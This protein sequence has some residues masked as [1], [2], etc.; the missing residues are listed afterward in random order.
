M[1]EATTTILFDRAVRLIQLGQTAEGLVLLR[2]Y[3]RLQPRD[4]NALLWLAAT[5]S[6]T[7]EKIS[8]AGRILAIQPD[9]E[10]ARQIL[11]SNFQAFTY[12]N[13]TVSKTAS[14][15]GNNTID[16]GLKLPQGNPF[17]AESAKPKVDRAA[18]TTYTS[19]K[20][21]T[22]TI[23]DFFFWLAVALLIGIG[24]VVLSSLWL[25]PISR[26]YAP[27]LPQE[28]NN[29]SDVSTNTPILTFTPIPT[30]YP[31]FDTPQPVALFP[32]ATPVPPYQP[33]IVSN[34]LVYGVT[35]DQTPIFRSYTEASPVTRVAAKA[36][37]LDIDAHTGDAGWWRVSPKNG[38]GWVESEAVQVFSD[39]QAALAFAYKLNHPA[40]PTP[41]SIEPPPTNTPPDQT[42]TVS[43]TP[44]PDAGGSTTPSSNPTTAAPTPAFVLPTYPTVVLP[45][46][47]P[48]PPPT[49]AKK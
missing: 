7:N 8:V 25:I 22:A 44:T 23:G 19:S 17:F 4:V 18:Q 15:Q 29:L 11:T 10:Q 37:I 39:R 27:I 35:L 2:R 13:A 12:A 43:T 49:R 34:A 14:N 42:P 21:S 47:K 26:P 24:V 38:G 28:S 46:L 31:I 20:S 5:T 16:D 41:L 33:S 9:N 30:P 36:A 3:I 1:S 6:D 45:T 40:T 48:T 32:T